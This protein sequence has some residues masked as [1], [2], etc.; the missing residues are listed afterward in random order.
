MRRAIPFLLASS[1]ALGTS[2]HASAQILDR[3]ALLTRQSWWDNRDWDWYTARIPFFESP[4]SDIDATYYYRWELLTKHLTYGS[5]ETG[6]TFTEFLDR[7]FWSGRYGSIS[8]PLGHQFA[9]LRWLDDRDIIDEFAR[10]WFE[11]PGAQPRSFSNWYA[12]AMWGV[13]EVLGDTSFLRRVL[14]YMKRQYDG[15]MTEHWD[16]TQRMFRWDGLHDG[17]E[18]NINSRQTNDIDAGAEGY[19]PS[20]NSYMYGDARAIAH[21]AAVLGDSETAREFDARAAD[22]QQRVEQQLWDAKREFFLHQFAHNEPAGVRALSRTYETGKFAGNPHGR[23]LIGYIPWQFEL[24]ERGKGYE[25]AWRFLMDT[26]YFFAPYGPTTTERH[27]PQFY[28][29]PTCC[30]WSGNSWPYATT[31]TLVAMANLLDAYHQSV[32]TRRDWMKLFDVYTHTQRKNGRP[33]IAEGANPDNGSWAGFDSYYHSEHY[34]HSGYIDL[35]VTG[36]VGLRP[37]A[38]DSVEVQPLAPESW[39]YFALDGVP[40]HGHTLSIVWDRDGSRYGRGKGLIVIANGRT[41]ASAPQLGRIVAL[42]GPPLLRRR[43][44]RMVNVAV[45]NGRGAY[46]QLR[47]SFSAPESP[48]FYLVDGNYWYH[49]SPAN[50]WTT[51]GSPHSQDTVTVDFGAERLVEQVK[52]Y[53][54]DDGEGTAVMAP[55]RYV[56]QTW[57]GRGWVDPASQRREPAEP[58]GHRANVITITPLRTSRIR[59][60]LEPRRGSALGMT[61]VEVWGRNPPPL[62]VPTAPSHDLAFNADGHGYPKARA[63]FTSPNDRVGELNDMQ[64][65]F[66][67]YSRNRWTAYGSPN[68]SDWV[69]IDFGAPRIVRSLEL[70]LWGDDRGV[71]APRSYRIQYWTSGGWR[72]AQVLSRFPERP[73]ASAVNVVRVLPVSTAQIRVVFDHDLPTFT[74]VTEIVIPDR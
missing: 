49:Q 74:G 27:D 31:Q 43:R 50:R 12:S 21:A 45:N 48:P 51:I 29:S 66:T 9:E 5:P 58:A 30:W 18:R 16:S 64:F 70:Y 60:L 23:E 36:V 2:R 25:S 26:A 63:S 61:E 1:I 19:R 40:Y 6:Y 7:P 69:E 56:V 54:L 37:R 32:V 68:A 53:F 41:I 55:A 17:M 72:P 14:P 44:E 34:F 59:V 42:L 73:A 33:Y 62:A 28:I 65:A 39:D 11:T 38:D 8:C 52:L 67:R 20:L 15:W 4:D 22:L 3:R 24:P 47:A 46:P 71:K 13:Y 10:Y 57:N 35:V